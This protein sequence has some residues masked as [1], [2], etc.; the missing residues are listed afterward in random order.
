MWRRSPVCTEMGARRGRSSAAS[1]VVVRRDRRADAPLRAASLVAWKPR[2]LGQQ[3]GLTVSGEASAQWQSPDDVLH[4]RLGDGSHRSHRANRPRQLQAPPERPDRRPHRRSS[5]FI[6]APSDGVHV[7]L[8]RARWRRG[9]QPPPGQPRSPSGHAQKPVGCARER[10][11]SA[12]L[13]ATLAGATQTSATSKCR[14]SLGR[15]R[16]LS[17]R[18]GRRRWRRLRSVSE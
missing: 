14:F 6:R 18:A 13:A 12:T 1:G 10:R 9:R 16:L 3:V 17:G 7:R 2:Q 15:L 11:N 4:H 8:G 5:A